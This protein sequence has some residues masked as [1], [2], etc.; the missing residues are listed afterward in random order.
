MYDYFKVIYQ[1]LL[2]VDWGGP[3]KMSGQGASGPTFD[4]DT[5][6]YEPDC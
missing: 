3:Q 4:L 2:C 1:Y 5:S 6:Q